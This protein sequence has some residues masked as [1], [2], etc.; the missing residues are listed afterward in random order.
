[1]TSDVWHGLEYGWQTL[2]RNADQ[3]MVLSVLF[4]Y[5]SLAQECGRYDESLD[6][7]IQKTYSGLLC[8]AMY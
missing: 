2:G 3:E 8:Q 4:I 5:K 6:N 7:S 1:M